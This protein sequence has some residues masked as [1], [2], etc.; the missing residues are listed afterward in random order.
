MK[1]RRRSV[2]SG[3]GG[4]RKKASKKTA[5]KKATRKKGRVN[6]ASLLKKGTHKVVTKGTATK[7]TTGKLKK[8]CMFGRGAYKG[9]FICKKAVR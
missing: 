2:L 9:K 6:I 7:K 4:T 5:K 1:K 8:G 3:L